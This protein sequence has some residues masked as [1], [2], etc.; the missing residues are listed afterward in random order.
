M[1]IK[2][3][4]EIKSY[5]KTCCKMLFDSEILYKRV[6]GEDGVKWYSISSGREIKRIY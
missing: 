6:V 1:V 3:S 2:E 4:L 5:N